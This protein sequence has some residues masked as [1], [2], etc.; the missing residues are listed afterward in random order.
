[1]KYIVIF[2]EKKY[3]SSLL[4][5]N[6]IQDNLLRN[7][8]NQELT[9][10]LFKTELQDSIYF[11]KSLVKNIFNLTNFKEI[12]RFLKIIFS[13]K[14]NEAVINLSSNILAKY[15]LILLQRRFLS[16]T[17][18][19]TIENLTTDARKILEFI[20]RISRDNLNRVELTPRCHISEAVIQ[21]SK[22]YINWIM[23]SSGFRGIDHM[24][25][26][27]LLLDSNKLEDKSELMKILSTYLDSASNLGLIF[28]FYNVN[29]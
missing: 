13:V 15:F 1:L 18:I 3:L 28:S 2:N 16:I 6:I 4:L 26:L 29:K 21:K 8:I 27:Y 23:T 10:V 25:Y 7:N 24:N 12:Y 22:E 5:V 19:P 11:K 14:S 9:V 20:K 17:I